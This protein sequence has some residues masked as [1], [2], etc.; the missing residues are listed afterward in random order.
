MRPKFR[1]LFLCTRNDDRSIF[2]EYFLRSMGGD[3]FEVY[4]GGETPSGE[5]NPLVLRILREAFKIDPTGALS[6]S[7]HTFTDIHF[8]FVITVCDDACERSPVFPGTPVTAHWSIADPK[9]FE[10][11]EEEKY[12]AFLQTAFH[13][14][15]RI[16]LFN[17]LP[18]EKLDHLQREV[19]TR[20][21]H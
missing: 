20:Q 9:A 6:R 13:V 12:H 21:V 1:V 14:K 10:G 19:S 18:M 7:W 5:V 8:D 2:A 11:S 3:R 15:R 16:E 4:S 17:C